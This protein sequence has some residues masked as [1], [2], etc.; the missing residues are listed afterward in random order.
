MWLLAGIGSTLLVSVAAAQGSILAQID[1]I[2]GSEGE[3]IFKYVFGG[4]AVT[5]LGTLA[6]YLAVY[7]VPKMQDKHETR[8]QVIEDKH[9][10]A[11]TVLAGKHE[12]AVEV[13][14]D[15]HEEVIRL[16]ADRFDVWDKCLHEDATALKTVLREVIAQCG[17]TM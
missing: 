5:I 1:G 6:F 4:G 11:I 10:A 14:S 16:L 17:K 15:K 12:R 7:V 3:A 2:P 8:L 13:L 9:S